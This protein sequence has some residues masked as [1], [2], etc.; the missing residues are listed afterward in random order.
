M[1]SSPTDMRS[2]LPVYSLSDIQG[3]CI[4]MLCITNRWDG[5]RLVVPY[6]TYNNWDANMIYG[7]I[8]DKGYTGKD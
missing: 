7:C 1:P 2:S 3:V 5:H 6:A 4:C 8:C